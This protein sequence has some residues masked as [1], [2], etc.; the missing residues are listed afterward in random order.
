[1]VSK[2]KKKQK[3]EVHNNFFASLFVKF[4]LLAII[5][6]LVFADIKVYKEKKKFDLQVGNL[7]KKVQSI[8]KD[9]DKLKEGIA[10]ADD[11]DYIEKIA[12]EELD[13]QIQDEKV[14]SFIMPEPQKK[15]E[16]NTDNN[17]WD[18]R[19]WLGMLNNSW[20]WMTSFNK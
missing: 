1:M 18:F 8:K 5:V 11:K 2:F 19:N 16:I 13:L 6:F 4:F 7:E 17:F 15:E 12:R 20:Q 3:S 10:R 9:N 14:V